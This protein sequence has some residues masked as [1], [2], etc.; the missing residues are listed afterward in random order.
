[1]AIIQFDENR[2]LNAM[3]EERNK[4]RQEER[5]R[6][7]ARLRRIIAKCVY[8]DEWGNAAVPLVDLRSLIKAIEGGEV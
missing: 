1:M 3:E 4:A 5:A 8:V 2:L 7:L 6:I